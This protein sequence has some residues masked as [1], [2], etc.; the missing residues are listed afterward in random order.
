MRVLSL[1]VGERRTGVAI[2]DPGGVL[3]RPLTTLTVPPRADSLAAALQPL[4]AEHEV[5][6]LVVG[7]PRRLSGRHGPEAEAMS[8]L[9]AELGSRLQLPVTLWDERLSTV[10]AQRLLDE[11]GGRGKRRRQRLDSIAAAVILQG[12]LDHGGTTAG[13]E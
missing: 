1:D 6:H 12:F 8:A 7:L 11:Q 3:A 10:E 5:Q 9:A 13:R 4:I 2:S